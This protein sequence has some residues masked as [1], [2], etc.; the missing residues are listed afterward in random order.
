MG[1]DVAD[2]AERRRQR[3]VESLSLTGRREERFDRIA[4]VARKVFDVDW[5]SITVLDGEQAWFPAAVGFE[6]TRMARQQTFCDRTTQ[7]GDVVLV[8]DATQDERFRDL[9]AVVDRGIRSYAGVPLR[10][11]ADNIVAVFCIYDRT[12]RTFDEEEVQTLEDLAAWAQ[13]ELVSSTEMLR[14]GQVQASML[15]SRPVLVDGWEVNG[16]CVPALA[17]GGDHFDYAVRNGIAHLGLGDVM[18]KGTGAALLGAGIRAAVRGTHDAVVSGVDLGV[19]VTQVAR[20]MGPDLAR[21]ESFVTLF[22]AA[23]DLDDGYLRY[24]DAGMGLC[25]V[26]RAD[27]AVEQLRSDDLPIGVLPDDHWSEQSTT[28]APGDRLLLFS[29]GLLDL[30][31]DPDHWWEPVGA[32]VAAHDDT[33]SLLA[34]IVRLALDQVQLDDV[35]AVAVFRSPDA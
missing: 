3:A 16:A 32:L 2:A 18:G 20:R 13:Q 1:H 26:V 23:V 8:P 30:I 17:V 27:G 10:D 33:T 9:P 6:G 5:S 7:V 25:V 21:A 24:V 34:A 35:T 31:D 19:T 14:A 4:R 12:V 22:E 15:P 11:P 28:L 29:D